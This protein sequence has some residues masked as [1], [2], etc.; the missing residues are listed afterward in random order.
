MDRTSLQGISRGREESNRAILGSRWQNLGLNSGSTVVLKESR[1]HK[2]RALSLVRSARTLRG[3]WPNTV[4]RHNSRT[5]E[6]RIKLVG[7]QPV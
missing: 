1:V 5:L 3:D 7:I 2:F 4:S 6:H